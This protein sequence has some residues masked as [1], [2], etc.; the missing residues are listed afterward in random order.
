[1]KLKG[2]GFFEAHIEKLLLGLMVA[3]AAGV[4]VLQFAGSPNAVNVGNQTLPPER[5][6]DPVEQRAR[7]IRGRM[8]AVD[9]D[10]PVIDGRNEALA[11]LEDRVTERVSVRPS[12]MAFG[13][14]AE[15]DDALLEGQADDVEY[16]M[17]DPPAPGA[18]VAASYAAT[19]DP[20]LLIDNEDLAAIVGPSQPFDIVTVTIETTYDGTALEEAFRTA[21]EGELRS[22]PFNWVNGVEALGLQLERQEQ[23]SDGSW[24]NT[25]IIEGLPGT[26]SLTQVLRQDAADGVLGR[27]QLASDARLAFEEAPDFRRP[28]PVR[29]IAGPEWQPPTVMK[30]ELASFGGVDGQGQA[31]RLFNQRSSQLALRANVERRGNESRGDQGDRG[32][33]GRPERPGRGGRDDDDDEPLDRRAQAIERQLAEIDRQL[34]R[35]D[36][37][38]IELGY[39]PETG[40]PVETSGFTDDTV[41]ARL[42]E[43]TEARLWAH[44]LTAKPGATY[45][46]RTRLAINNPM[47]GREAVLIEAQRPMAADPVLLSEPSAWSEPLVVAP[48]T[49]FFLASASDG[50]GGALGP[51]EPTASVEVFT[52]YYGYYRRATLTLRPG[53]IVVADADLPDDLRLPVLADASETDA[54]PGAGARRGDRPRERDG[55]GRPGV[56]PA[57]VVP[58]GGRREAAAESEEEGEGELVPDEVP[59][60]VDVYLVDVTFEPTQAEGPADRSTQAVAYF[61]QLGGAGLVRRIATVDRQGE[62]YQMLARSAEQGRSQGQARESLEGPRVRE[63]REPR[64]TSGGVSP[65]KAAPGGGG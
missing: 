4:V 57:G 65:G 2:V 26:P 1:M 9:V 45:R 58:L 17:I 34:E 7:D 40:L 3:V 37:Q 62:L 59:A 50:R 23:L 33:R 13:K 61:S 25:T 6:F 43:E 63:P 31:Q 5:A 38:M 64:P 22:L 60:V 53:D 14:P 55:V 47:F 16:A 39:D 41:D 27:D 8:T 24:G 20:A 19:I 21:G 11:G 15:I 35:I 42:L 36:A 51:S 32:G 54:S 29:T 49:A 30:A 52:F 48:T 12:V 18:A 28:L 10:V 56:A 44:D 46:Y